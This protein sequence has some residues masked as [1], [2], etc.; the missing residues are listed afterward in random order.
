MIRLRCSMGELGNETEEDP[1]LILN[2]RRLH[3]RD[4]LS[5]L[6]LPTGERGSSACASSTVPSVAK[7]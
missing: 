6:I 3:E 7:H 1:K 2:Y 5:S 4:L